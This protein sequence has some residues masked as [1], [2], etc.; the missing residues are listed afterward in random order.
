MSHKVYIIRFDIKCVLNLIT[1][2]FQSAN[3]RNLESPP[4]DRPL[5]A[6]SPRKTRPRS[7]Y[8]SYAHEKQEAA[9]AK[10]GDE[11]ERNVAKKRWSSNLPLCSRVFNVFEKRGSDSEDYT[12]SLEHSPLNRARKNPEDD[13][14]RKLQEKWETMGGKD[15]AKAKEDSAKSPNRT[16]PTSAGRSR[17]PRLLTSPVKQQS[18]QVASKSPATGTPSLRKVEKKAV[19]K[20]KE[21]KRTSRVDQDAAPSVRT[22]LARPSS[23]PYK[24]YGPAAKDKSATSPHRRAA[25]TSLPRPN[26]GVGPKNVVSKQMQK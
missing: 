18:A 10:I 5:E 3:F 2:L 11:E 24:S 17:I 23:L 20:P 12:D 15:E 19:Q 26:S 22:H 6:S 13:K 25:S 21:A 14:F 8:I 9:K 1:T 4:K 7:S 16:T